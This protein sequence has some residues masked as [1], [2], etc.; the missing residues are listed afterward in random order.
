[1]ANTWIKLELFVRKEAG[2]SPKK[3]VRPT[4]SLKNDLDLTGDDA[5]DFM[6]KFFDQFKVEPGDYTFRQYF[7]EEGFNI[8]GIVPLLFS[9]KA[10]KK[11]DKEP[12]TLAMLERAIDLGTWDSKKLASEPAG[13]QKNR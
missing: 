10:R 13:T 7:C 8:I 3:I 11:Y 2:L 12:L 6:A 9:K 1:M 5:N 4:D